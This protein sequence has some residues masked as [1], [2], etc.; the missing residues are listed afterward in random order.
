MNHMFEE[1]PIFYAQQ[2]FSEHMNAA[3]SR[4]HNNPYAQTYNF[5]CRNHSNFSWSQNNHDHL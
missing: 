5:G 2:I 1:C 3:Y 4:P